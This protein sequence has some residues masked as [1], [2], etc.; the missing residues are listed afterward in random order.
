MKVLRYSLLLLF[1][2]GPLISGPIFESAR[3]FERLL[4]N[5]KEVE[6]RRCYRFLQLSPQQL[7]QYIREY[8]IKLIVNLRGSE[9]KSQWYRQEHETAKARGAVVIDIPTSPHQAPSKKS[10]F[11]IMATIYNP[12]AL[13][14]RPEIAHASIDEIKKVIL[15]PNASTEDH[16]GRTIGI[17]Y[18]CRIGADRTGLAIAL[19]DFERAV[20]KQPVTSRHIKRRY[21]IHA[22]KHLTIKYRH[23]AFLKKEMA[24][25]VR[26]WADLRFDRSLSDALDLY[27]G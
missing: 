17:A 7:D 10:F 13:L 3:L 23:F 22:L 8:T 16:A 4:Y 20:Q 12:R 19:R 27:P 9:P 11:L 21:L 26:K 25:T 15:D 6:K 2:F 18:H 5:F 14:E 1:Y 24:K